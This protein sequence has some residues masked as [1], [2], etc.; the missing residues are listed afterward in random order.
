MTQTVYEVPLTAAAQEFDMTI[1]SIQYHFVLKWNYIGNNWVI[2][3]E[4]Q[5]NNPIVSGIP[6]VTGADL[7]A[8]YAS[9]GIGVE[10]FV[11]TDNNADAI[12][13]YTNLGSDSHLYFV[14]SS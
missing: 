10:L 8:Q 11:Q 12:P 7:L 14:V 4:D 9:L 3:I 1:G 2:D 5:S 13:T 6:L